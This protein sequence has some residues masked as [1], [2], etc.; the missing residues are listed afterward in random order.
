F[1]GMQPFSFRRPQDFLLLLLVMAAFFV[2]GRQ[3]SR[4][5][6][7][8][9]MLGTFI[10]LAFRIQRDA[11]CVVLPAIAVIADGIAD[12]KS[13]TEPQETTQ[14]WKWEKQLVSVLVLL[15]FLAGIVRLPDD[16]A[17]MNRAGR[18][19]P[20]NA[21]DF[22]RT[23]HLP[24]PLFNTYGWGGFLIWYLPEYPV[25][26][27]ARLNLYGDETNRRYFDVTSGKERIETD[28]DFTRARTLLLERNAPITKA[29]TT[30]PVFQA[31]FRVAYQ[32]DLATVL[33]RQ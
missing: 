27:D 19:F 33:V 1:A 17:L 4:D 31:Q 15:V 32:D 12:W 9:G 5:L 6:F 11:W 26:I 7:K 8:L 3:R 20:V 29:L 23:N 25:A 18:L 24:E 16:A 21:C 14:E 2:L 10:M 30:L 22:I 28:P 13:D